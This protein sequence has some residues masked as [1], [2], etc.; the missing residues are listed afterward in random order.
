MGL[1]MGSHLAY[2][3]VWEDL[4]VTESCLRRRVAYWKECGLLVRPFGFELCP[5]LLL[6]VRLCTSY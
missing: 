4:G 6:A 1:E 3:V 2:Q 5:H